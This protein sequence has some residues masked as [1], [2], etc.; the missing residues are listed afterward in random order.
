[1]PAYTH[2]MHEDLTYWSPGVND[3][4]GGTT[5][6]SPVEIKGRWQ[7]SQTLFRDA[8]GRERVSEAVVYVDRELAT[9]G[10]LVR[11]IS[12]EASPTAGAKEI[13]AKHSSP[14]LGYEQT[15][16]KVTL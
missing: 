4:F 1:M 2:N 11:G 8:Q 15:L 12:A 14:S 6:G 9:G 3:G 10:Y 5:F 13:R 16:Y 7:D